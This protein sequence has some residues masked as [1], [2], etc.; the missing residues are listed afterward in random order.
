MKIL[1]IKRSTFYRYIKDG[2]VPAVRV[3]HFLRIR[4]EDVFDLGLVLHDIPKAMGSICRNMAGRGRIH[5]Y[6]ARPEDERIKVRGSKIFKRGDSYCFVYDLPPGP[7]GKRHQKTETV[8]GSYKD[9][10]RRQREILTQ[11]DQGKLSWKPIEKKLGSGA[12][13]G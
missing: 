13:R 8:R 5:Q 2:I 4:R 3:G 7:E 1:K 11:I 6:P 10:E 12:Y 9:A